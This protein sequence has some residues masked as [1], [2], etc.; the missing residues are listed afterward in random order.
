MKGLIIN[1]KGIY[2][3]Y[4]DK[5]RGAST[6]SIQYCWSTSTSSTLFQKEVLLLKKQEKQYLSHFSS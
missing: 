6:P 2:G 4:L 1:I 3:S 5:K